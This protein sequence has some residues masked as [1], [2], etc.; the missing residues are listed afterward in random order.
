MDIQYENGNNDDRGSR[1]LVGELVEHKSF[2][3]L[4]F[5]GPGVINQLVPESTTEWMYKKHY[6]SFESMDG[7]ISVMVLFSDFFQWLFSSDSDLAVTWH[8]GEASSGLALFIAGCAYP[9]HYVHCEFHLVFGMGL[10]VHTA[11]WKDGRPQISKGDISVPSRELV[12]RQ[13][14]KLGYTEMQ[15]HY[16]KTFFCNNPPQSCVTTS[17]TKAICLK[18]VPFGRVHYWSISMHRNGTLDNTLPLYLN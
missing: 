10:H 9:A 15:N 2:S 8:I 12:L 17:K 11:L 3:S 6:P 18:A 7:M 13:S 5:T 1:K 16:S 14:G 4:I